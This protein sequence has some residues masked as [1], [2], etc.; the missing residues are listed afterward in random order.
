MKEIIVIAGIAFLPWLI[1][2]SDG[3]GQNPLPVPET[4][5]RLEG[6][7]GLSTRAV[8]DSGYEKDLDVCFARQ[9]ETVVSLGSYGA[10]SLCNATRNGGKGN[11][12][13]L[14]DELQLYPSDG[15]HIRLHGYYPAGDGMAPGILTVKATFVIDGKTDIMATGCLTATT[16]E[17][18]RTC[19]FRHLLTQIALVCYSDRAEQ[20]GAVTKIEAV[21]ITVGQQLDWLSETPQLTAS[22]T[23]QVADVVVQDIDGLPLPKVD[24]GAGLPDAQG[25]IL[26]PVSATVAYPIQ[27]QVTTT[28]DGNGNETETVSRVSVTAEGGF[29][30]GKRHVVSL[31]FTD[32]RKIQATTVGV[33]Q[34]TDRDAGEIPI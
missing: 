10:W 1:A 33:E 9:D 5:V 20:W 8:I 24:E 2:C 13:I 21:G 18:V 16:Y 27:L 4:T 29:Q 34:W 23:R 17:P 30:A 11:R 19:T 32:G 6:A 28:K 31:F 15:S 12:P 26:L 7:I 14:F 3:S 25:Y 22:P